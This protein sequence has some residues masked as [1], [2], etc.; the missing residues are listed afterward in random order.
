MSASGATGL[1]Q[2]CDP[3]LL[4]TPAIEKSPS[5]E[6]KGFSRINA[7]PG[8]RASRDGLAIPSEAVL[9]SPI[10][11]DDPTDGCSGAA[12]VPSG[13]GGSRPTGSGDS[14]GRKP[15]RP[16]RRL[17][18]PE[19]QCF[20]SAW[21][22]PRLQ[23][24]KDKLRPNWPP[25]LSCASVSSRVH[26]LADCSAILEPLLKSVFICASAYVRSFEG[27]LRARLLKS[28]QALFH[29]SCGEAA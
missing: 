5:A 23:V 9:G 22:L 7:N 12:A 24:Q 11:P 10:D 18:L 27:G 28:R 6:Q 2:A 16:F 20:R 17:A 1:S 29:E 8:D 19:R 13:W 14:R 15:N 26:T 4:A 3:P 21:R 25:R